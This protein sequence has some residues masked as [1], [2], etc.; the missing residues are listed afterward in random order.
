[1]SRRCLHILLALA[2]L[3]QALLVLS[4][5]KVSDLAEAVEHAMVHDVGVGHHHQG[6]QLVQPGDDNI[7]S[8]VFHV[9]HDAA[10]PLAC[11]PA[12]VPQV[13]DLRPAS[14]GLPRAENSPAAPCLEGPLRPP[15]ARA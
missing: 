4:P 12:A 14:P 7:A 2:V 8:S 15:R 11:L 6:E 13:A 5:A 1:M 9:H 10:S 3:F